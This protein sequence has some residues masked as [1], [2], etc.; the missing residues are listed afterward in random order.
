MSQCFTSVKGV[1]LA[2][3]Y[4]ENWLLKALFTFFFKLHCKSIH[5]TD[6]VNLQLLIVVL[7]TKGLFLRRIECKWWTLFCVEPHHTQN[8]ICAIVV[9]VYL[10]IYFHLHTETDQLHFLFFKKYMAPAWVTFCGWSSFALGL[11]F[12]HLPTMIIVIFWK[13]QFSQE[14]LQDE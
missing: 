14:G 10:C 5:S 2:T 12:V 7:S 11:I 4:A 6:R 13:L 8:F 3:K 9:L 1:L